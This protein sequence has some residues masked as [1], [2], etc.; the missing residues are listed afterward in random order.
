MIE[1]VIELL[2][3]RLAELVALPTTFAGWIAVDD[4]HIRTRPIIAKYYS[5]HLEKFDYYLTVDFLSPR[6]HINLGTGQ[7]VVTTPLTLDEKHLNERKIEIA[8]SRLVALLTG[9]L[10]LNKL[11]TKA[12]VKHSDK[13]KTLGVFVVHGHDDEMK[14][15]VARSLKDLGLNPIILHEKPNAGKTIIEK[16]ESHA[17]VSFAVV[18]L[19]PDDMAFPFDSKPATAKPRPRQNV[20]LELGFFVGRLGRNRVCVLKRESLEFPSDFNGVVYSNY[21]EAGH[22]R[23]E[24]ARELKE[25]GYT[26]DANK[27]L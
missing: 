3:A 18:L 6:K 12:T 20:V 4:W 7:T 25:A 16:F 23:M 24:M 22:W 2:R 13:V 9:L 8:K 21:D 5:D 14:H 26:I 1:S 19:S 11:E 27:L 17:E 15:H 10:D